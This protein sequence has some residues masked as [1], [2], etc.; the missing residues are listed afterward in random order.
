GGLFLV[1][2]VGGMDHA[3]TVVHPSLRVE[4]ARADRMRPRRRR[5]VAE[6][7]SWADLN[8]ARSAVGARA[9]IETLGQ[10]IDHIAAAAA[11]AFHVLN[12]DDP[13]GILMHRHWTRLAELEVAYGDLVRDIRD[14]RRYLPTARTARP[15]VSIAA[16]HECGWNRTP[17]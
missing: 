7:D 10:T 17:A 16:G 13:A 6:I 1:F 11:T 2:G 9:H 8:L 15:P 12:T 14:G 5:I 3:H 4:V